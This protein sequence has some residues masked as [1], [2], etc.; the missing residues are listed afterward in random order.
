M[1][2]SPLVKK[3]KV[4]GFSPGVK[5]PKAVTKGEKEEEEKEQE[6]EHYET[7]FSNPPTWPA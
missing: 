7:A 4:K 5:K 6:K 2:F 3:P 1:G